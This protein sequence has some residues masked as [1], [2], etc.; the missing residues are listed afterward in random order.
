[1]LEISETG[2]HSQGPVVPTHLS[3]D[4][5]LFPGLDETP[6]QLINR[7]YV[8]YNSPQ[9]PT[10]ADIDIYT[11][12]LDVG[13]FVSKVFPFFS[14]FRSDVKIRI[15]IN[16]PGLIHGWIG[17]F[18]VPKMKGN[19]NLGTETFSSWS[20]IN[21]FTLAISDQ[22]SY[23]C[24]LP[25]PSNLTSF[26]TDPLLA[27]NFAELWSLVL[28][29]EFISNVVPDLSNPTVGV[30]VYASFVNSRVVGPQVDLQS[31]IDTPGGPQ[32]G[33]S[34]WNQHLTRENAIN[35]VS[36]LAGLAYVGASRGFSKKMENLFMD[37]TGGS[38]PQ[39]MVEHG[40]RSSVKINPYGNVSAMS[41]HSSFSNL[42]EQENVQVPSS[43]IVGFMDNTDDIYALTHKWF[44]S[45]AGEFELDI[46]VAY[47][48]APHEGGRIGII[49][50]VIDPGYIDFTSRFFRYWRGSFQYRVRVFGSPMIAMKIGIMVA[51]RKSQ[52]PDSEPNS[53]TFVNASGGFQTA[54]HTIKG[55][56]DIDITVPFLRNHYWDEVGNRDECAYIVMIPL[57]VSPS[58]TNA[59]NVQLSY[60]TYKRAGPDF[61]YGSYNGGVMLSDATNDPNF[62]QGVE[63][64]PGPFFDVNYFAVGSGQP[65][66]IIKALAAA[67]ISYSRF[68]VNL[69]VSVST[70]DVPTNATLVLN[71]IE[72][73]LP[74]TGPSVTHEWVSWNSTVIETPIGGGIYNPSISSQCF[75]NVAALT[76]FS[77]HVRFYDVNPT[78]VVIAGSTLTTPLWTSLV[79]KTAAVPPDAMPIIIS[80][81]DLT[82]PV[83]TSTVLQGRIDGS[84][85]EGFVCNLFD[86]TSLPDGLVMPETS[87]GSIPL[88]LKRMT[89]S[90]NYTRPGAYP[91]SPI[92][93]TEDFNSKASVIDKLSTI[94]N[95]WSGGLVYKVHF[96]GDIDYGVLGAQIPTRTQSAII[97]TGQQIE[98][99]MNVTQ[100]DTWPFLEFEFPYL[101]QLPISYC[102]RPP[103]YPILDHDTPYHPEFTSSTLP[104]SS[105]VAD[106]LY[107]ST[108]SNFRFHFLIPPPPELLSYKNTA[109]HVFGG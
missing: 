61:S 76:A 7:E 68:D 101:N 94:Y 63:K 105:P 53:A 64:N 15:Q 81:S 44:V 96:Y 3:K 109:K 13:K 65:T 24:T 90:E 32:N 4:S 67:P 40:D 20:V 106:V 12:L 37:G 49:R 108:A 47:I 25:W 36:G 88:L 21:G 33:D 104:E 29:K 98:L 82:V 69:S 70:A 75:L 17:G 89:K 56:T 2:D 95:F 38:A 27:V 23:E 54:V 43:G 58:V 46:P 57:A 31:D 74:L 22:E 85:T 6:R 71:G 34:M 107:M 14:Y 1:M 62:L 8:I 9:F 86:N 78:P 45:D 100:Q 92:T 59:T 42:G 103:V 55:T 83:W 91:S 66:S 84:D 99:G 16:S 50:D 48:A 73:A 5:S 77:C 39:A 18:F 41:P 19:R 51:Y 60:V 30:T 35:A 102:D 10:S 11:R 28:T 26:S 97:S 93:F 79:K 72:Y 52:L 80:G 87:H